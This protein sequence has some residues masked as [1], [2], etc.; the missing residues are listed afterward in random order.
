[1]LSVTPRIQIPLDEFEFT[2]ARSGGP[3]GQNVNKVNS[4][5]VL[6]WNLVASPT[7]PDDVRDRFLA[8]FGTRV[9]ATGEV[10]I[11]S[12]ESRDQIRNKELCLEKLAEMLRAVARPPKARRA[13]KPS[14]G[15]IRRRLETKQQNSERKANRRPPRGEE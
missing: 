2:Y 6:R 4:K 11:T 10:L 1:M 3:G 14:K 8:T 7:L 5:A 13:T 15:S 9:L 12:E